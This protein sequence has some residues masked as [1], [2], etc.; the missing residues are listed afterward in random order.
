MPESVERRVDSREIDSRQ[1][2]ELTESREGET[3]EL[4]GELEVAAAEGRARL[5]ELLAL[6]PTQ[7]KSL[8]NRLRRMADRRGLKLIKSRRRDRQFA[9]HGKYMLVDDATSDVATGGNWT[10]DLADVEK[11]LLGTG[12]SAQRLNARDCPMCG[13]P[14]YSLSGLVQGSLADE[15]ECPDCGYAFIAEARPEHQT[16][17]AR[18][19]G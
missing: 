13:V 11:I 8:E 12:P 4:F 10:L 1:R 19:G 3:S 15:R 18:T 6:S 5:G 7:Y 14:T 17:N 16:P 2:R 9:D